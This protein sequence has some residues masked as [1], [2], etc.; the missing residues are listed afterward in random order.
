MN[1]D[2][3]K[4]NFALL[5]VLKRDNLNSI[6]LFSHENIRYLCGFTG[7]SGT[8]LYRPNSMIFFTDSRYIEQ[9]KKEIKGAQVRLANRGVVDIC[10]Y[11]NADG[12]KNVG[13]E[14]SGVSLQDFVELKSK[15]RGVKIN[16]IYDGLQNL[17]AVKDKFEFQ[18]IKRAI[19]IAE[20]A[21][22]KII[23]SIKSGITE[24]ELAIELE[25]QM[26]LGGSEELPFNP[27]VLFGKH[28]SLPHGRPGK[29]RLN[30]GE[31]ILI[32]F[33]A[34]SG[35]YCSD[36]TVTF[37]FDRMNSEQSRIYN[38]VNDARKYA[39]ERIREGVKTSEIDSVARE[40]LEKKGLAKYFGHGLGHGVGLAIHESPRLSPDSTTVLECG[41]IFT[42]EP[43]VYIPGW[44]GVRLE[45][46]VAV[47]KKGAK[48][49]TGI[50]KELRIIRG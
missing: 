28:A 30:P 23:E 12:I 49:L 33:G 15:L 41:M 19:K 42:V 5:K 3:S 36:E 4:R 44:G 32:D 24:I 7:S 1:P 18:R 43:G 8:L 35:G 31:L 11:L 20:N 16:P 46:M 14:S 17:R 22:N 10:K 27:I 47:E 34:R 25:H 2:Y 50:S 45:D 29:K 38:A 21:L 26:K 39:I 37:I 6:L 13:I 48:I 40:Y 9:A